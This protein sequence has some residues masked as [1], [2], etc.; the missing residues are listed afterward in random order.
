MYIIAKF[1]IGSNTYEIFKNVF[2][3]VGEYRIRINGNVLQLQ[4]YSDKNT[5]WEH[6]RGGELL[7]FANIWF[8]LSENDPFYP[9]LLKWG[10]R[11]NVLQIGDVAEIEA[12]NYL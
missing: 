2:D 3:I 5:A 9:F 4:G 7:S 6:G 10:F 8:Q 11:P 12:E 1:I